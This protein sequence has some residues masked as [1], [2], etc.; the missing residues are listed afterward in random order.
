M[1]DELIHACIACSNG[2]F[3]DYMK[4]W[5]ELNIYSNKPVTI[6][7]MDG[8]IVSGNFSDIDE[9]GA[10]LLQTSDELQR[11]TCGEVSLRSG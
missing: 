9:S 8:S 5:R 10:L 7:M 2:Q 6:H 11:F 3:D 1:I 4:E